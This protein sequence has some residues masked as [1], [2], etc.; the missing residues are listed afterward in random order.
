MKSDSLHY[1]ALIAFEG[2]SLLMQVELQV[3]GCSRSGGDYSFVHRMVLLQVKPPKP[4]DHSGR[5]LD[6]K[7]VQLGLSTSLINQAPFLL[8]KSNP[9]GR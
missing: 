6:E 1:S 2:L 3:R 5:L 9:P 8:L 4:P 7:H